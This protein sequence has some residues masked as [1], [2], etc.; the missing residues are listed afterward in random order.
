MTDTAQTKPRIFI[1]YSRQDGETF[2]TQLR[3]RLEAEGLPIWQDR[4][5]M[6]GGVGWWQQITD[7]LETVEFMVLV[8]TPAALNS[9]VVTREWR[10]ARQQGVCVYPVQVPGL[11]LDFGALP[12]WMKDSHF[13][14]LEKEWE[15]FLNYLKNPCHAVRVPFMPPDLPAHLVERPEHFDALKNQLLKA[16]K[17]NPVAITTALRGAG[18]FGKTTLASALCHDESIQTAFDDGILWVTL[19]EQPDLLHELTLLYK[20]LTGENPVFLDV[21]EATRQFAEKLGDNDC[22]IVIDDVWN[23]AHVKPFLGGGKR[24]ARLITTRF[25]DIT[26]EANAVAPVEVDEMTGDQAVTMLLGGIHPPA[27]KTPFRQ[28]AARLGEWALLLEIT[29]GILREELEL[30]SRLEK[31]LQWVNDLL[32]EEGI[33]GIERDNEDERRRSAGGVLSGTLRRLTEDERQQFYQLAIF[34]DDTEIPLTSIQALWGG[35]LVAARKLIT[36]LA[37]FTLLRFDPERELIRLHDVVH[38]VLGKRLA[39]NESPA[40]VHLRLIAGWRDLYA[41]P[42]AYAW[43]QAAYHLIAARQPDRLRALLLD[44]RWL[45]AKLDQT[46][47]NALLADC[48]MLLTN[49]VVGA[50]P[51]SPV[52]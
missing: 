31:A 20:T 47:V 1:S 11:P 32:D 45:A 40:Q 30:G 15:T 25:L 34:R 19:G 49:P 48:D 42:D 7:A 39:E 13:Y 35:S 37:R 14:N 26:V 6:E 4:D 36:R 5:R 33:F 23:A 51:A 27:D 24:C 18:V 16:D 52:T 29:N 22:L 43:T 28:L 8:A 41:L 10:Y 17:V 12:Q 3:Q 2:A 44:Y 9:T 38:E 50:R 46:G 21:N